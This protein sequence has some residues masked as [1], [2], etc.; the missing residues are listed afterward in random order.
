MSKQYAPQGVFEPSSTTEITVLANG[1]ITAN[2]PVGY[3]YNENG[4]AEAKV[5]ALDVNSTRYGI[6]PAAIA[7][8]A[9]GKIIIRGP[10]TLASGGTAGNV[11]TAISNVGV[12]TDATPAN[13]NMDINI[14]GVSTSATTAYLY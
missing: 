9:Y 11:I 3:F 4:E 6:A 8:T 14:L 13:T 12:I 10:V 2:Y 1:A 5:C 7:D